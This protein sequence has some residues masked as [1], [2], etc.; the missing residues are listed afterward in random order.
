MLLN[1]FSPE[2][3]VAAAALEGPRVVIRPPAREDWQDWVDCRLRNAEAHAPFS[4]RGAFENL[5][6]DGYFTRLA[7]YRADWIADRAYVFLIFMKESRYLAG[8]ITINNVARGAGQMAN[9]GYWLDEERRGQGLMAEA[10]KLACEFSFGPA[11]LHRLQ[12]GC[13]PHNKASRRVLEK[14][15]FIEEGLA[16]KFI[17]INGV[18]ED[19]VLYGLCTEDFKSA[20]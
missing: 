11:K 17:R 3:K 19:H 16:K 2:K 5:T 20:L 13:L 12:A 18:W 7:T 6:R 9:L 4:P 15:G 10:V 14:C 8:G 1:L